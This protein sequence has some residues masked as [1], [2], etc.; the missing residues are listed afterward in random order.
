MLPASILP[1]A[2][3]EI[4]GAAG[5]VAFS[6]SRS[7]ATAA[8]AEQLAAVLDIIRPGIPVLVG[9]ARGVDAAVRSA[10]ADAFIFRVQEISGSATIARPYHFAK[11]SQW[12]IRTLA[13]LP[14]P[15]L[16]A[17]PTGPCPAGLVPSSNARRCFAGHGSGTWATAAFAAGLNIHVLICSQNIRDLN[18]W[19]AV[20]LSNDWLLIPSSRSAD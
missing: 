7:P 6:G 10:R 20:P 1:A 12:M 5:A 9:C 19:S 14:A 11:R 13:E 17:F 3:S 8:T 18:A 16:V 15:L 4:V 2:V